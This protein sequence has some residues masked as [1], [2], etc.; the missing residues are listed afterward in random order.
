[1][2]TSTS[3]VPLV[4]LHTHKHQQHACDDHHRLYH[5]NNLQKT[6]A[7]QRDA[8]FEDLLATCCMDKATHPTAFS[9]EIAVPISQ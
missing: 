5:S 9:V 2:V 1:M 7:A 4:L 8:T 3:G 6:A